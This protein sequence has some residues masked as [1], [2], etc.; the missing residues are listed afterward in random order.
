MTEAVNYIALSIPVF[1]LLIGV[2]VLLARWQGEKLYRLNDSINDLSCGI[3]QQILG[4]FAKT[5]VFAGYAVIYLKFRLFELPGDALRVW[6]VGFLG[7]DFCYYWFH[8][9]SHELNLAWA[10]HIVHHQSEE[11]NLAVALRQSAFQPFISAVFYWPLALLGLP[12]LPFLTLSAFNTLYQFWIHTRLIGRLGAL[13]WILN[14]PSHHRVHHGCNPHYI[15]RN[16]GGTLIVW[17]RLFGTFEPEGEEVIYGV[18]RPL[19][20]WNPLWANLHYWA[21]LAAVAGRTRRLRD[22]LRL[23]V[24]PPHWRP[25]DVP[26]EKPAA[27]PLAGI[28]YDAR[29]P[30][31]FGTYILIHFALTLG[32]TTSFLFEHESLG[33]TPEKVACALWIVW[34]LVNFGAIFE[35]RRWLPASEMGRLLATVAGVWWWAAPWWTAPWSGGASPWPLLIAVGAAAVTGLSA[36]FLMRSRGQFET[37]AGW[38]EDAAPS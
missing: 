16:H 8:R 11:F 14:T 24:M 12:P 26:A 6:V 17:D 22:K 28:R 34:S 1:F 19:A 10:A 33:G 30:A 20:S 4:L 25:P 15:D 2:E 18:T 21:E 7:V 37:S 38:M 31:R 13:E 3:L 32:V 9:A 5:A 36:L 29:A 27:T 35:R 23:W